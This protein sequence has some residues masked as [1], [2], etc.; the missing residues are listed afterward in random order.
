[1]SISIGWCCDTAASPGIAFTFQ[2]YLLS[3]LYIIRT[4][5]TSPDLLVVLPTFQDPNLQLQVPCGTSAT[6]LSSMLLL[7]PTF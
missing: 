1:M 3:Y 6:S 2:R 5:T 4:T 7:D